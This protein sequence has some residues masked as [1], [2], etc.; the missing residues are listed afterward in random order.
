MSKTQLKKKNNEMKFPMKGDVNYIDRLD[1]DPII[2]SQRYFVISFISPEG[3]RNTTLRGIKVRFV[4]DDLKETELKAE[5]FRKMDNNKF[6]VYVG[7]IGKWLP[8]NPDR[9]GVKSQVYAESE[10]NE[11]MKGYEDNVEKAKKV[12]RA[13][14]DDMKTYNEDPHRRNDT[15]ERLKQKHNKRQEEKQTLPQMLP[16]LSQNDVTKEYKQELKVPESKMPDIKQTELQK[17][18]EDIK[19]LEN[20][21]IAKK[22]AFE[23]LTLDLDKNIHKYDNLSNVKKELNESLSELSGRQLP[24]TDEVSLIKKLMNDFET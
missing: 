6:D 20:M 13:R 10:L 16:S 4:S 22:K 7:E 2:K 14:V 1:E 17:Q 15:K 21:L 24:D 12:H 9:A 11:L 18:E 3:I 8:W 23:Q 19:E 5:E